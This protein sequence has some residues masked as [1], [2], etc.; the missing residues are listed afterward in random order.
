MKKKD[1]LFRLDIILSELNE[2]FSSSKR[3]LTD[4]NGVNTEYQEGYYRGR[5]KQAD[6]AIRRIEQLYLKI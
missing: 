3:S 1:L 6:S 5:M 4:P 2:D